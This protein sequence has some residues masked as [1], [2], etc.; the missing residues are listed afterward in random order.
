MSELVLW[1]SVLLSVLLRGVSF[2]FMTD[3]FL[4]FTVALDCCFEN[5]FFHFALGCCF[6]FSQQ[7]LLLIVLHWNEDYCRSSKGEPKRRCMLAWKHW[8]CTNIFICIIY[9]LVLSMFNTKQVGGGEG[10]SHSEFVWIWSWTIWFSVYQWRAENG[11]HVKC[12]ML[13]PCLPPLFMMPLVQTVGHKM[14]ALKVVGISLL[15]FFN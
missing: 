5:D 12:L 8:K 4:S 7:W 2:H 11:W 10:G 14:V 1:F 6:D 13:F 15:L 9:L 3:C